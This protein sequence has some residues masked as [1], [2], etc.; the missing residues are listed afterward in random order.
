[1]NPADLPALLPVPMILSLYTR[2]M[3][4]H[5]GESGPP[6][7]GCVEGATTNAAQASFYRSSTREP[8]ALVFAAYVF[9]YLVK[10]HCFPDGNKRVAWVCLM[11]VLSKFDLTVN[12]PVSEAAAMVDRL[13]VD[14]RGADW[15]L[16][17]LRPRLDVAT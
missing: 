17:W 10:N 7:E 3:A 16:E 15:V 13:L 14:R 6:R 9:T 12:A 1:M 5:G 4:E 11:F 2:G 8:D